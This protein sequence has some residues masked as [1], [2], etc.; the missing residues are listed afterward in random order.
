MQ[1]RRIF[2][3]PSWHKAAQNVGEH[4]IV[5]GECD[6]PAA[7]VARDGPIQRVPDCGENLFIARGIGICQQAAERG[8]FASTTRRDPLDRSSGR[9]DTKITVGIL[10]GEDVVHV[11]LGLFHGLWFASQAREH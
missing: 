6:L 3:C 5:P 2:G 8:R 10:R 11:V 1:N 4:R 9:E 7:C